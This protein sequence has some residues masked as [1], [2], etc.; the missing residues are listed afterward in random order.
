MVWLERR[1]GVEIEDLVG[2]RLLVCGSRHWRGGS[3][4]HGDGG[5]LWRVLD[6]LAPTTVV[7]GGCPTGA[8]H[9]ADCWAATR[10][11]AVVV[12]RADWRRWGKGAGPRRN[13]EMVE[14]E[15]GRVVAVVAFRM[16]MTMFRQE[17]GRL[18]PVADDGRSLLNRGTDDLVRR[19][20]KRKMTVVW[21]EPGADVGLGAQGVGASY[22]LPDPVALKPG[23]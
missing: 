19:A 14:A 9:L 1:C 8:D 15:A 11:A 17:P 20:L 18:V 16:V 7:H 3:G 10:G 13:E 22:F 4:H 2:R 5:M 21:F 23:V 6:R 12:Y